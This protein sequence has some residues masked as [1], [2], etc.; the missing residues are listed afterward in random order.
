MPPASNRLDL[1]IEAGE[2]YWPTRQEEKDLVFPEHEPF[3]RVD[4]WENILDMYVNRDTPDKHDDA[5]APVNA[6]R[7]FFP[8]TELYEKA[9]QIKADR[10]DGA[11]NMDTRI[12]NSMKAL[13]FDRHRETA[14]KRRRG[15]LRRPPPTPQATPIGG[16]V[17]PNSG[18][19]GADH[20]T[21]GEDDD[22][23]F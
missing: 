4:E 16:A 3:K 7:D 19:D 20:S 23:P 2:R 11:G 5:M 15:F 6:K 10:I 14:G 1:R 9:L 8:S 18:P 13:G 22:L 12:S 17:G 21:A